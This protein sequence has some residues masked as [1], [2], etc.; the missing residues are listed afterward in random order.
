MSDKKYKLE[1]I[2][3]IIDKYLNN[4]EEFKRFKNKYYYVPFSSLK[5]SKWDRKFREIYQDYLKEIKSEI[6]NKEFFIPDSQGCL[7]KYKVDSLFDEESNVWFYKEI[8]YK[9][10]ESIDKDFSNVDKFLLLNDFYAKD[11]KYFVEKAEFFKQ[12]KQLQE[13]NDDGEYY[14][15]YP[16]INNLAKS[17]VFDIYMWFLEDINKG[18]YD[19]LMYDLN[20]SKV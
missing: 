15:L 5:L 19:S 9:H 10:S 3:A 12:N 20:N 2:N 14:K 8:A 11:S 17:Y 6:N 7:N 16:D 4:E 18:V 13:K 1:N